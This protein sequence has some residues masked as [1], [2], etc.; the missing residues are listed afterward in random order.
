MAAA[1]VT[2][3]KPRFSVAAPCYNEV[4][5]IEAVVTQW[6]ALLATKPEATEIVLC[7]DGSTDGTAEVL[8]HLRERFPRL[9]VV[10]NAVNAGY[11]RALSSAIAATGGEYVCTIDSDGQFDLADGFRLIDELDRGGYDAVTGWRKRKNDS[12]AR[13]VANRGMNA[14]VRLLFG[15]RL[16]D[17]NCA[18]KVVKGDVLRALPIEARG[19]PAPTEICVRLE[20][21]GLRVGERAVTHHARAAGMSKLRPWRTAW[22]FLRFLLHLRYTLGLRRAGVAIEP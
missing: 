9:R 18:I 4:D 7:D 3:S 1:E 15:T 6:D 21:R 8:E 10:H 2:E 16:R 5:A 17:T 13:V 19:Y 11:G 20:A 14:L 22:S 12:I